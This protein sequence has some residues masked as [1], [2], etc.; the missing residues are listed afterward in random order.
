M[1][2]DI[3]LLEWRMT[4]FYILLSA[5]PKQYLNFRPDINARW[6]K[7]LKTFHIWFLVN[8][9]PKKLNSVCC[10][11]IYFFIYNTERI[12][13]SKS[14]HTI[15][16]WGV[17]WSVNRQKSQHIHKA[18]LCLKVPHLLSFLSVQKGTHTKACPRGPICPYFLPD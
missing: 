7:L 17:I 13:N 2:N 9:L 18:F 3:F 6:I 8:Q 14:K 4:F 12:I 15:H 16:S 5:W 10:S 11:N 1:E